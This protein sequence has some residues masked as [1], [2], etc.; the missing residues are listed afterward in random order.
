MHRHALLQ[1][2]KPVQHNVDLCWRGRPVSTPVPLIRV[3]LVA[4]SNYLSAQRLSG[5]AVMRTPNLRR[6]PDAR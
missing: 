4:I 6:R 5:K 3:P 1:F 2:F